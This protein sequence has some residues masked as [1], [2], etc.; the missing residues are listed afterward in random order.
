VRRR[1]IQP[2][3]EEQVELPPRDLVISRGLRG[4]C[5]PG[6][7]DALDWPTEEGFEA[8][9]ARRSEA[10]RRWAAQR[11]LSHAEFRARAWMVTHPGVTPRDA[12]RDLKVSP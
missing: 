10:R 6:D 3:A 8:A 2:A 7:V 11:A 9:F 12:R 1:P 4:F 5:E